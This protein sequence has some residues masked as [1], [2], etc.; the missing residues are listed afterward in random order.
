MPISVLTFVER[1][2]PR[3]VPRGPTN[4]AAWKTLEERIAPAVASLNFGLCP[5]KPSDSEA[6]RST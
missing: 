1:V 2:G 6:E 3:I 5:P 4:S